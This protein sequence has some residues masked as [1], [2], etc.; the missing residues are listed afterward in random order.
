MNEAEK[1]KQKWKLWY[2][3]IYKQP[4]LSIFPANKFYD[5][6]FFRK[7]DENHIAA[8]FATHIL[9][10]MRMESGSKRERKR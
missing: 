8:T 9:I 4:N 3:K 7:L 5:D 2:D 6:N 1:L 10:S